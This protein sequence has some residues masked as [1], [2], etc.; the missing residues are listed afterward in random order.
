MS[1]HYFAVWSAEYPEDG[2]LLYLAKDAAEAKRKAR[3]DGLGN[4]RD[5]VASRMTREALLERSQYRDNR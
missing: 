1:R 2:S 3:K 4:V 5:L